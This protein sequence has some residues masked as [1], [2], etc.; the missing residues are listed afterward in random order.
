MTPLERARRARRSLA[1]ILVTSSLL[2]AAAAGLALHWFLAT[3]V[4]R[5][6]VEVMTAGGAGIL[7]AGALVWRGRAVWS[8][9][10]AALWVEARAPQ[11][12]Y[13]FVTAIEPRAA[14][15]VPDLDRAIDP[16]DIEA[17]V[18]RAGA[19]A[20]GWALAGLAVATAVGL[21]SPS[22]AIL[23][24]LR[25]EG[26]SPTATPRRNRLAPL[27]AHV[28]PPAYARASTLDISE[29]AI[30]AALVGST[31]ELR[32]PGDTAGIRAAVG[33]GAD[34][35]IR[36]STNGAGWTAS[37]TM[38]PVSTVVRLDDGSHQRLVA[39]DALP[40]SPPTVALERPAR[41]STLRSA[42]G[43]IALVARAR[44]DVGLRDARF[45]LI[46]SS[47]DQE[48][49][50][51]SQE[52]VLGAV[53]LADA[54]QAT[55]GVRLDL[56]GLGLTPGGRLSIRAVAHDGNTV[57]GPGAGVSETRTFRLAKADEYDSISVEGAPPPNFDSSYMS[58]RMI[59]VET[60]TLIRHSAR[61]PRAT[62]LRRAGTLATRQDQ[63]RD[64]VQALLGGESEDEGGG[65]GGGGGGAG[66]A[67]AAGA[68]GPAP[69]PAWQRALFDTAFRAMGDA[70][71]SLV[72][73]GVNR[74]LG[75]ELVAL[76]TLDKARLSARLYLR[77]AP[78]EI[79]VNTARVRLSGTE[80][81]DAAPR[82][83]SRSA[84]T[85]AH[86]A[87]TRLDNAER[88]VAGDPQAAADSVVLLR[89]T[90][91][92]R[93]PVAGTALGDAAAALRAHRDPGSSLAA[94]RRAI[95]GAPTVE[96]SLSAWDGGGQ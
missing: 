33:T 94:A 44:D 20:L 52:R 84:D 8:L 76:R 73:G 78:P 42:T 68:P 66:G 13:A 50:F 45:E 6:A 95:A 77:G 83:P 23:P 49:A 88:L 30:I 92:G 96:S 75:P 15:A 11:L 54:R 27:Q 67:A 5:S 41:D 89:A 74:A 90:V 93:W 59:V 40:D 28:V 34:T 81:P 70:S 29:P 9:E 4:G 62:V 46:I 25:R 31:I 72:S 87:V 17:L 53:D 48:G 12:Q 2:W 19:R 39:L 36:V 10:R 71:A 58:Q 80:T 51:K 85:A 57:S 79:V 22:R 56:G 64:R 82:A 16:V 69:L 24:L 60:R 14:R 35:A 26:P 38:P 7:V 47:G 63:L 37:V 3:T 86:A 61:L 32:G 21:V 1:A 65:G 43:V 55:L 91:S 18:R